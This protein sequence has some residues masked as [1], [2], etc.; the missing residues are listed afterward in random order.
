MTVK[1]EKLKLV[2]IIG[3]R[4]EIIKMANTIK[5]CDTYFNHVLVHTGQNWDYTLNQVF[6]EDLQLREP[7]HYLEIVGETLGETMGNVIAKSYA[8]LEK[9]K[10]DGILLASSQSRIGIV[11][12]HVAFPGGPRYCRFYAC[13]V[14]C[15]RGRQTAGEAIWRVLQ[16]PAERRA[17]GLIRQ[18]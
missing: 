13:L 3:T 8:M 1:Y 4:P 16:S 15:W 5:A 18:Y 9:E 10:P 12:A 11:L 14:Q 6:F 7:D 2:T 17:C